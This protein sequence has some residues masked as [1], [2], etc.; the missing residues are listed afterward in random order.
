MT[1]RPDMNGF[2]MA[3]RLQLGFSTLIESSY[4]QLD[5]VSTDVYLRSIHHEL[6]EASEATGRPRAPLERVRLH[7]HRGGSEV[8]VDDDEIIG[9]LAPVLKMLG[10]QRLR[11]EYG[12]GFI[13]DNTGQY[14]ES[15][16][17]EHEHTTF[18][19][20]YTTIEIW[21]PFHQELR[22]AA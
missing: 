19:E 5:R 6:I 1:Q 16:T 12:L 9:G 11:N 13:V 10:S 7:V 3:Y 15:L 20:G 2:A 14:V 22:V 8:R 21:Q 4:R 18:L 17:V